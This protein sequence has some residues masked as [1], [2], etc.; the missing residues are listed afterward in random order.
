MV[1]S[2]SRSTGL[3]IGNVVPCFAGS[4]QGPQLQSCQSAVATGGG[5][6][7]NVDQVGGG[8]EKLTADQAIRDSGGSFGSSHRR[9]MALRLG[10][11]VEDGVFGNDQEKFGRHVPLGEI[12][13][14]VRAR[15]T[16]I[17][18]LLCVE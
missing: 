17:F 5:S 12:F 10:S 9:R 11:R 16:L 8:P 15:E 3:F 13:S 4:G 6:R 2:R 14:T 1:A 18:R 7:P